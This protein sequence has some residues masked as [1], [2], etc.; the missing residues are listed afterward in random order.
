MVLRFVLVS[1]IVGT[2]AL[3]L[4][5]L[6]LFLSPSFGATVLLCKKQFGSSLLKIF[7]IRGDQLSL[8][9]SLVE[10]LILT[11]CVDLGLVRGTRFNLANTSH[12]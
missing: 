4:I 10:E 6:D 8:P 11:I 3:L 7:V 2:D 12:L 1:R 5:I 9:I